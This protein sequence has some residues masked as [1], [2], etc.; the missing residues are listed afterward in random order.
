MNENNPCVLFFAL[1]CFSSIQTGSVGLLS[2]AFS[3]HF[4]FFIFLNIPSPGLFLLQSYAWQTNLL[5][6]L[7][8]NFCRQFSWL[9]S[10]SFRQTCG[11]WKMLLRQLQQS[12]AITNTMTNGKIIAL[13]YMF[14]FD[15][16]FLLTC[17]IQVF[18][19][20]LSSYEWL[21]NYYYRQ[22]I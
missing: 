22:F 4:S 17:L 7:K 16:S 6:L 8:Q 20:E 19:Y 9:A 2:H 14:Q 18:L 3:I 10:G 13:E 5:L 12:M 21:Y 11:G 1:H 15:L